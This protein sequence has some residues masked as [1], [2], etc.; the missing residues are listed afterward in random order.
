[1]TGEKTQQ[2]QIKAVASN[3]KMGFPPQAVGKLL[4]V[5]N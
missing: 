1:M 4:A 3:T 2:F 5:L